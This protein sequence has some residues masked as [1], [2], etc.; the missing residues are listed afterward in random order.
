MISKFGLYIR[1]IRGIDSMTQTARKLGITVVQLSAME[2]A[3]REISTDVINKIISVY[4]LSD[5]D[6][7]ELKKA[8]DDTNKIVPE[9]IRKMHQ[10]A[11]DSSLKFAR[12]VNTDTNEL[13]E[14]LRKALIND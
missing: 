6:I 9:E 13:I 10:N 2:V 12:K 4:N 8:C 11:S 7:T 14:K 3:R 5:T 1:K